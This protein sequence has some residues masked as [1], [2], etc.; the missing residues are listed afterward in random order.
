MRHILSILM[1]WAAAHLTA[2][3]SDPFNSVFHEDW[4]GDR[5]NFVV[6]SRNELQLNAASAGKSA[7]WRAAVNADSIRWTFDVRMEF[8]PSVSNKLEVFLQS[9]R[10]EWPANEALVLEIGENGS[11]DSWKIYHLKGNGKI[12]LNAG[13]P[14]LFAKGP[15]YARF[16]IYNLQNQFWKIYVQD[17]QN[18][19]YLDIKEFSYSRPV[20]DSLFYFGL[21]C[22]YTES[23]KTAFYFDEISVG[24]DRQSPKITG[25]QIA[26]EKALIFSFD[27][28]IDPFYSSA[29]NQYQLQIHGLPENLEWIDPSSLK[30]TYKNDIS[31]LKFD[32]LIYQNVKDVIGNEV[33]WA[34]YHFQL[35]YSHKPQYLDLIFTELMVDPSPAWMLPDAEYIEIYNRSANLLNLKSCTISD[36]NTWVEF[37]DSLLAPGEFAILCNI[38]DVNAFR[39]FGK[40]IPLEKWPSLNNSGD[41]LELRNDQG[42]LIHQVQ[43][44]ENDFNDQDK[45][46]GGYALEWIQKKSL[47]DLQTTWKFS[48]HP[49]G[50]TPGFENSWVSEVID[51]RGPQLV[52]IFPLSIWEIKLI[53]N[54]KLHPE[55][56]RF[57]GIFHMSPLKDIVSAEFTE[58]SN[59]L[60]LLLHQPMDPGEI[61]KLK[62]DSIRDCHGNPTD[63]ESP[64]IALGQDPKPGELVWSEILFNPYSLHYD[65]V[66]IFNKSSKY[67]SLKNLSFSDGSES[68]KDYPLRFDEVLKPGEY[69]AFTVDVEDLISVYPTHNRYQILEL[70]LPS[71]PDEGGKIVLNLNSGNEK[72]TIDS[73]YYSQDWHHPF[74]EDEEGKSLEKI[75]MNLPSS[76]KA[77]WTTAGHWEDFA[78]PGLPNSQK[79]ELKFDSSGVLYTLYTPRISPDG[80]GFEDQ[81]QVGIHTSKPAYYCDISLYSLSGSLVN[82]IYQSEVYDGQIISWYG[83]D[84]QGNALPAGNYIM[85]IS[86]L[87]PEG[88]KLSFKE[89]ISLLRR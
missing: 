4:T 22:T 58:R 71:L 61:Y 88:V 47:C 53:F 84:L 63:F 42:E 44:S 9:D 56:T 76:K 83:D 54:E 70:D 89:R 48:K 28:E 62:T 23:R 77:S 7:I 18:G 16:H 79:T 50:G 33:L 30:L 32:T 25:H 74:V 51:T 17:L 40:T 64:E 24:V 82:L 27:K 57:P 85:A 11:E 2:Q 38:A 59:E 80:D 78:T 1:L 3:W 34:A 13:L 68:G 67:I 19:N 43:Y 41:F 39:A 31:G 29:I 73:L 87:H 49:L 26:D 20:T 72:T 6:N 81:I 69:Q 21:H 5:E 36:E 14:E 52:D 66:E 8:D 75:N 15:F 60:I 35:N 12:L 55:T 37:P 65:F 46:D 45:A 10:D 86:L